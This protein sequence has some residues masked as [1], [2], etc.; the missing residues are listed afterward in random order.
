[1]K[2]DNYIQRINEF[3]PED[4]QKYLDENSFN[5]LKENELRESGYII[6]NNNEANY[7]LMEE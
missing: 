1:M 7:F 3:I 5:E 4:A 6:K 2:K